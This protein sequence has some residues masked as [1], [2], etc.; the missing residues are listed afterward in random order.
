[1]TNKLSLYQLTKELGNL[2]D[3]I[4]GEISFEKWSELNTAIEQKIQGYAYYL[5]IAEN[6]IDAFENMAKQML[7]EV[8]ERR[9]RVEKQKEFLKNQM[10]LLGITKL[11]SDY[12][13]SIVKNPPSVE[14]ID[15]NVIDR[16][17]FKTP[18]PPPPPVPKLD[19][20]GI[21]DEYKK[22]GIIPNGVN[23]IQKTRLKTR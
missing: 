5:D 8:D 14:V 2:A 6:Q 12:P 22:S 15:E 9:A 23:I 18:A 16:Q 20:K 13:V 1:M 19:K 3:P 11:E 17:Y 4:T 21:L 10:E 7:I